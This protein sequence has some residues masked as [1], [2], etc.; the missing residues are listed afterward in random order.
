MPERQLLNQGGAQVN[1][2]QSIFISLF[3]KKKFFLLKKI[4]LLETSSL[5]LPIK[6]LKAIDRNL[7]NDHTRKWESWA[8]WE[9]KESSIL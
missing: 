9:R 8:T 6:G 4:N 3:H 5:L 1:W 2:L 7:W